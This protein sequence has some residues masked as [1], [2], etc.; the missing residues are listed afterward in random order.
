MKWGNDLVFSI[1]GKMFAG[2]DKD[3]RDATFGCKVAEEDFTALTSI[4][5]IRP[6]PYAARFSWVAVDDP[7]LLPEA[8]AIALLRGS[9]VLVRAKL[10]ARFRAD[11][12]A[13]APANRAAKPTKR[14]ALA[15]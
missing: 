2:F 12:A 6:A 1:G 8:E 13:R 3:G 4:E 5:G 7:D 15:R 10:S 11:P 9:F 14:R